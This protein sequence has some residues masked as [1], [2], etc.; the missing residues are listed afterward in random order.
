MA[1]TSKEP[2]NEKVLMAEGRCDE[3]LHLMKGLPLE[4][5]DCISVSTMY[6][7]NL[8]FSRNFVLLHPAG[9]E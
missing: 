9:V 7:H 6:C 4:I 1:I 2:K 8:I 3:Q 5:F